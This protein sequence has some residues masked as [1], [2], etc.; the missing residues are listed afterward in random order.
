M[1]KWTQSA[2]INFLLLIYYLCISFLTPLVESW[3][4]TQL[5]KEMVQLLMD[6]SENETSISFPCLQNHNVGFENEIEMFDISSKLSEYSSTSNSSTLHLLI[7]ACY[8]NDN[9]RALELSLNALPSSDKWLIMQAYSLLLAQNK[10]EE[11]NL[12]IVNNK[13]SVNDLF[14]L[15]LE[16]NKNALKI[17]IFPIAKLALKID[18]KSELSW[19]LL[20]SA[21]RRIQT[22]EKFQDFPKALLC[23]DEIIQSNNYL[24]K[25]DLAST[26]Y[27]RGLLKNELFP[28]F[29]NFDILEDFQESL[30]LNP[31]N[32]MVYYKI[33]SLYLWNLK[34]TNQARYYV[35]KTLS[36]QPNFPEAYI[37][38]GD[39]Y[40]QQKEY[41]EALIAYQNALKI[42]PEWGVAINRITALNGKTENK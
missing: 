21:C 34:D 33:S 14:N 19:K 17:D 13:I 10:F 30:N 11:A 41:E 24:S 36:L 9:Q 35:N 4:K 40:F 3:E 18:N 6:L 20:L 42:R 26:F 7:M 5:K 2:S 16:I 23:Y 38:L 8:R 32:S 22:T 37:L 27:Y 15:N 1:N 29:N 31:D 28:E 12:L 39:I 25:R